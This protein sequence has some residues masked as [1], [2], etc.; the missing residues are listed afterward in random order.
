MNL[1]LQIR[2]Q[3]VTQLQF[4]K[5]N[6]QKPK[7][8]L[9]D[10]FSGLKI[11]GIP[12]HLIWCNCKRLLKASPAPAGGS[13]AAI[14]QRAGP[15]LHG[16][17]PTALPPFAHLMVLV[18]SFSLEPADKYRSPCGCAVPGSARGKAKGAHSR[19]QGD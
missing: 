5:Q 15:R 13:Q 8:C 19:A 18:G 9:H 2:S 7:W 14:G 17:G 3:D 6:K 4:Q 1:T 12:L 11:C 16:R 10:I